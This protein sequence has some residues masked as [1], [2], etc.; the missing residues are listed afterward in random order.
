MAG[1]GDLTRHPDQEWMERIARSATPETWAYREVLRIVS[2]GA[3]GGRRE[4]HSASGQKPESECFCGTLGPL[5]QAGEP[6]ATLNRTVALFGFV[7]S[8]RKMMR[9]APC[10]PRAN[11]LSQAAA[12]LFASTIAGLGRTCPGVPLRPAHQDKACY[13]SSLSRECD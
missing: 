5:C 13:P 6:V 12:L 11:C 3:G 2:V 8:V 7:A 10:V 9:A 1:L 4:S